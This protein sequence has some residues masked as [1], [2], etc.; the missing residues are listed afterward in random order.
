MR[1]YGRVYSQFWTSTDMQALSD[2]GRM[3]ALYLL[4]GPH[5]TIAGVCR[6][7]DGYIS[8]DLRWSSGRVAKGFHELFSKGFCNRC[9]TT[10]WVWIRKFLEWN[11]PE[12]PNQWKAARKVALSIPSKCVFYSEFIDVFVRAAGASIEPLPNPSATVREGLPTQEQYQDQ[13]QKEE[14]RDVP[15]GGTVAIGI[16]KVF[17]H[18]KQSHEHPK[19]QLDPSRAKLITIALKTYTA[20]DLCRSISGYLRSPHHMG[21]NPKKTKY[22]D[23]ELFLRDAKHIDAGLKFAEHVKAERW[24]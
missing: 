5:G 17:D 13:E 4:S 7:P 9:E 18:W 6:L 22:D 1:E 23:I 16:Q 8:E 21:D 11:S 2:D 15:Q 3:L 14:I 19:A 20:D 10:K 12:N 24:Q